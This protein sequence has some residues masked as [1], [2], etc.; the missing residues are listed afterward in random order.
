MLSLR[1]YRH[2]LIAH[3]HDHPQ[4]VFGLTGLLEFEIAGCASRVGE[5]GLA[6]IPST[7]HHSCASAN[8]SRCLVLDVPSEQW[9]REH[10]GHHTEGSLRLLDRPDTLRLAPAQ[11]S[12]VAWLA[13]SA[14]NDSV[15]AEQGSV[16][17]LA[18][19]AG[20]RTR[21]PAERSGAGAGS[22]RCLHRPA[23]GASAAGR[24]PG[25]PGRIVGRASACTFA[26]GNRAYPHG[27]RA[28]AALASRRSTLAGHP[29]AGRRDRRTGGLYLA[30]RLHRS[31]NAPARIHPADA[32]TRVSRQ[33]RRV[34][35]QTAAMP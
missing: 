3:S 22:D 35:R 16:L 20:W 25:A 24:R 28:P 33:K 15:I 8:G 2:D 19:L 17:L 21:C 29:P 27:V 1:N 34:M 12:L 30:K 31:A 10:L 32:A 13:R 18:S 5:Q 7:I 4:L 14:T 9:V 26:R 23:P 11:H 6:V